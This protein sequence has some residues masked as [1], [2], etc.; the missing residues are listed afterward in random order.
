MVCA[1]LVVLL[2]SLLV[3]CYSLVGLL[4]AV[5][6]LFVYDS[7]L[8]IVYLCLLVLVVISLDYLFASVEVAYVLG[9]CVVSCLLFV[10]YL[11]SLFLFTV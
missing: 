2:L 9:L 3:C 10:C 1:L 8:S 11:L 7:C 4:G 6:W 5:V